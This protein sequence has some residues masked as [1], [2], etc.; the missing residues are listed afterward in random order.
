M[1]EDAS[2][3]LARAGL[4]S[5]AQLQAAR[6]ACAETGGTVGEHL[7]LAGAIADEDLAA[8][9]RDRLLVP[10]IDPNRLARIPPALIEVLP[11]D[12]AV[13]LRCVPVAY[14]RER[15]LLLAM[16]DPS[17]TR[18]VDEIG[19]FT[20][21]SVVRTVATQTQIA[22]CLAHYYDT[23]TELGRTLLRPDA[24]MPPAASTAPEAR[25][26]THR[27]RTERPTNEELEGRVAVRIRA[28]PMSAEG[29]II[30]FGRED[31]SPTGP[32]KKRPASVPPVN[33]PELVP[34]Y[35]EVAVREAREESGRAPLPTVVVEVE[36]ADA[37][38]SAEILL[39]QVR[40]AAP[41]AFAPEPG[42]TAASERDGARPAIAEDPVAA[43]P[44]ADYDTPEGIEPVEEPAAT[45]QQPDDVVLLE[46]RKPERRRSV[47]PTRLGMAVGSA[48][49][50]PVAAR[51]SST[52][53]ATQRVPVISGPAAPTQRYPEPPN[54][55]HALA[56]TSEPP[57]AGGPGAAPSTALAAKDDQPTRALGGRQP[58][59]HPG[60]PTAIG[61]EIT[62][63]Y[64]RPSTA[65]LD[66]Q[67]GED[68]PPG[69]TIPPSYL[70]ASPTALDEELGDDAPTPVTV[71]SAP[72]TAS[73]LTPADHRDLED[74]AL[75]LVD[76]VRK[77][78][79]ASRRDEIIDAM[80]EHLASSHERVAFFVVGAGELRCF[81]RRGHDPASSAPHARLSLETSSTFQDIVGTRLPF[82]GPV[83]DPPSQQLVGD[84]LGAAPQ[85]M[86]G[87]P[88]AVR[89]RVVGV[90][91]A[92]RPRRRVFDAQLA[93]MTRAAG[94]AFERILQ[95]KKS[96]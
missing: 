75:V 50:A 36:P 78:D 53:A 43:D 14:D 48:T 92:D 54:A 72:P 88:V 10:Q 18:A 45:A 55:A 41:Q 68:G 62:T 64:Q 87:L 67:W 52:E 77:L 37:D 89:G 15:H 51:A 83:A 84:V 8:F 81:A 12:M 42:D 4:I 86:L 79:R 82:R 5:E 27:R 71:E 65:E 35:G 66:A 16:A 9:Y 20:G 25:P 13:E 95:A 93:V 23:L 3:L 31:T 46:T 38:A 19:F 1:A 96:G 29:Q 39:D 32:V 76:L 49:Q 70:G 90:L 34:R 94:V 69:T 7:V 57:Q 61:D 11:L 73:T 47:K 91:Y 40:R 2:A 30:S 85:H 74:D 33:P 21:E 22:W 24:P 58:E 80:L 63:A 26:A 28:L 59:P 60:A 6:R 56:P 44:F 17:A